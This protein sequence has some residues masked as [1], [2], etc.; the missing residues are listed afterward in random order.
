MPKDIGSG[1]DRLP[2]PFHP[3]IRGV[4]ASHRCGKALGRGGIS[5]GGYYAYEAAAELDWQVPGLRTSWG[6][7]LQWADRPTA[8][9]S[10]SVRDFQASSFCRDRHLS[11]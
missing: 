9:I 3:F 2:S 4:G 6:G 8:A 1:R 10:E 5:D 11:R 7:G